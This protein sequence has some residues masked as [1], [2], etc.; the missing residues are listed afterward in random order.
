MK[1]IGTF[2]LTTIRR[3]GRL[4]LLAFGL[5][6]GF[7]ASPAMLDSQVVYPCRDFLAIS[8]G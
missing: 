2:A 7:K 8:M 4:G 6:A 5:L 3:H 1:A